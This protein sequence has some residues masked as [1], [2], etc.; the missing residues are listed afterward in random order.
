MHLF[1]EG[2]ISVIWNDLHSKVNN[3]YLTTESW[4]TVEGVSF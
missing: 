3:K 1:I 2:G 4:T